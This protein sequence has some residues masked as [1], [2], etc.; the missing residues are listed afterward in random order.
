MSTASSTRQPTSKPTPGSLGSPST[1][2]GAYHSNTRLLPSVARPTASSTS[3]VSTPLLP[4]TRMIP[5][6]HI[7]HAKSSSLSS[8]TDETP[9]RL[10]LS[11]TP[12]Y[13][14]IENNQARPLAAASRKLSKT[15]SN[16]VS[17]IPVRVGTTSSSQ[18]KVGSSDA[19]R[20]SV[21]QPKTNLASV[22]STTLNHT[23]TRLARSTTKPA[24]GLNGSSQPSSKPTALPRPTNIR[25]PSTLRTSLAP[26]R[27]SNSSL[28]PTKP[29]SGTSRLASISSTSLKAGNY[30]NSS[31]APLSKKHPTSSYSSSSLAQPLKS[32]NLNKPVSKRVSTGASKPGDLMS[33]S[34][35]SLAKSSSLHGTGRPKVTDSSIQPPPKA[36]AVNGVVS[37]PIGSSKPS[38]PHKG[39]I[40][41]SNAELKSTSFSTN[42][43][44]AASRLTSASGSAI[45]KGVSTS[46][47]KS[48][49]KLSVNEVM[50][51]SYSSSRISRPGESSSRASLKATSD[52][53]LKPTSKLTAINVSRTTSLEGHTGPYSSGSLSKKSSL[54]GIY[55]PRAVPKELS[56]IPSP[57]HYQSKRLTS[58]STS[59]TPTRKAKS[60]VSS[61]PFTER[62]PSTAS[63]TSNYCSEPLMPKEVLKT[64]GSKLTPYEHKEILEYPRVYYF[65]ANSKKYNSR[66]SEAHR[67]TTPHFLLTKDF[68]TPEG[69]LIFNASDHLAYRYEIQKSLGKGSFGQVLRAYD[70]KVGREVAIKVIRNSE[71]FH[72]QALTE[73]QLLEALKRWDHD[74]SHNV[75]HILDSF[76][77]RSHL[78]IVTE[79]YGINLYEH[80][81]Q[82]QF[83][84]F[85]MATVRNFSI[86]ILKCLT[87][88]N[89]HS[90]IHCDLKPENILL[91]GPNNSQIKVIDF[92][93]SCFASQRIYT[94][95]QSR[96][97]RS[98]EVILE[99]P[100]GPPID[101]WS[102][103]C[104][105]AELSNGHPIFPG[106][107]EA[108]Q[109]A[110]ILEVLGQPDLALIAKSKRRYSFFDVSGNPRITLSP[111]RRRIIGSKPLSQILKNADDLYIDFV[112]R[113]LEFD[114]DKRM[115]PA[116]AL[117]HPW[118]T[119]ALPSQ[120]S[121][122]TS[123]SPIHPRRF[124][125]ASGDLR[126]KETPCC[127]DA[128]MNDFCSIPSS[129]S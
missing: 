81:K 98:P 57:P 70:Y 121:S 15:S 85:R 29:Q 93:S 113:C 108:E 100:Y 25:Q 47:L 6:A 111:R 107:T 69:D 45:T 79:L 119:G 67:K 97:Y 54:S 58:I 18:S 128:E 27:A 56:R 52:I 32:S 60:F 62:A 31:D 75:L 33:A 80:I 3:K 77:F 40:E 123:A 38:L 63:A 86:Q 88:L 43:K 99:L 20:N 112:A 106:E 10:S 102:F 42:L 114:P 73:I 28:P 51:K 49:S 84:G 127:S 129:H 36:S 7:R 37:M 16:F 5:P 94:Y 23:G 103:G 68:S 117:C 71:R 59:Q 30:E 9:M 34:A 50:T 115:T 118:I 66:D 96:F 12:Q 95:I 1:A 44:S 91:A 4:P 35:V 53:K 105:L 122:V 74:G 109:M 65:G 46:N 2:R 120:P 83:V 116:Q 82:N 8:I 78:C 26:N 104:I 14:N 22:S 17:R 110:C 76:I 125:S 48:S 13:L 126:S 19:T 11:E 90:V 124:T 24:V 101:M 41:F 39:Q 55:T 72:R 21:L 92:G 89:T 87:L 61:T 64:F